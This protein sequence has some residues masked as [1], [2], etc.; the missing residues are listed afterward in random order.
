MLGIEHPGVSV[1]VPL[2]AGTVFPEDGELRLL[3][4]RDVARIEDVWSGLPA[5]R[6]GRARGDDDGDREFLLALE[7]EAEGLTHREMA[8]RL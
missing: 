5:P 4:E 1:S 2:P 8:A 6:S 3:I 7:S